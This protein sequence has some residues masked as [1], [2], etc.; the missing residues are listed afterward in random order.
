MP[1]GPAYSKARERHGEAPARAMFESGAARTGIPAGPDGTA[2][3]LELTQ[4]DGTT[5]ELFSDPLL[6]DEFGV[7]ACSPTLRMSMLATFRLAMRG[8]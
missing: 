5:L 3:G 4:I 7:P 2:F 6:A 1:A 8:V